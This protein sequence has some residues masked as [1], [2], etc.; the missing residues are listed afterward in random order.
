M[1]KKI[2]AYYEHLKEIASLASASSLMQWDQEVNMPSSAVESRAES[3]S[4]LSGIIHKKH[5]DPWFYDLLKELDSSKELTLAQ[6][7]SVAKT[8]NSFE[9]SN[10]LS[11]KLVEK[12]SSVTSLSYNSWLKARSE[13]NFNVFKTSLN[14]LLKLKQEEASLYQSS[15]TLYDA[16]LE[17]Y[18]PGITTK[19]IDPIFDDLKS[20]LI[21]IINS[22]DK[23]T[24]SKEILYQN[25]PAA[26]QWEISMDVLSVCGFDFKSGRKDYSEHP[27][28]IKI[29]N[30]DVRITTRVNENDLSAMLWST[31]H[32]MGHAMYEQGLMKQGKPGAPESEYCSLSIHESQSRFYENHIGR[33]LA[34]IEAFFSKFKAAFP[35]QF[36]GKNAKALYEA[37]NHIEPGLIRISADELTY[38][39]HIIIRY[40]IEKDL[41]NGDLSVEDLND[42]WRESY[43]SDL[44]LIIPNDNVGVLQDVHWAHGSFGYFPTYTLGSIY[45]AQFAEQL[46]KENIDIFSQLKKETFGTINEWLNSNIYSKGKLYD[47]N[48]LCKQVT[49]EA[50]N[51]KSFINY[52]KQKFAPTL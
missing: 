12:I 26:K 4:L 13:N 2:D 10:K 36:A 49:G 16:L 18:E 39:S 42:A 27:F 9:R 30:G 17:E 7:K 51:A 37:I 40:R 52:A 43:K 41:I 47:S 25:Y 14:E 1:K 28:S 19:V 44:G 29:S 35:R 34:F 50:I 5:T 21:K 3:L 33:S 23:N 31:I 15:A 22:S 38:H 11:T 20:A 24:T 6:K 45:A 32:E 48:E 8:L 46:N